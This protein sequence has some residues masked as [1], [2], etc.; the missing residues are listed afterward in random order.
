MPNANANSIPSS[1]TGVEWKPMIQFT[2]LILAGLAIVSDPTNT[3]AFQYTWA[4]SWGLFLDP[5][6]WIWI[7]TAEYQSC[8]SSRLFPSSFVKFSF[9]VPSFILHYTNSFKIHIICYTHTT[10]NNPPFTFN[11]HTQISPL[12][13]LVTLPPYVISQLQ[14][15]L[16][17]HFWLLLLPPLTA[18][19]DTPVHLDPAYLKGWKRYSP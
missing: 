10:L 18:T 11:H 13:S 17:S 3:H 2:R 19:T 16:R 15:Q 5:M 9:T 7:W 1:S 14:Y 4:H 8:H 6:E 12:L